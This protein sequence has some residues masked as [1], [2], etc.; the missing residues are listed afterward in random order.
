MKKNNKLVGVGII[1]AGAMI[2]LSC[3]L[4]PVVLVCVEAVLLIVAGVIY[5][6]I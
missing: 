4:P 3:F 5:C 1:A 2:L 6:S